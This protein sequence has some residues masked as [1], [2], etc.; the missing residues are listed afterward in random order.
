[1][2][3]KDPK[4]AETTSEPKVDAV[5]IDD[6]DLEAVTGGMVSS[7]VENPT[8]SCVTSIG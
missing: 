3:E 6:G 2:D 4:N 1:M 5:E 7:P 8:T